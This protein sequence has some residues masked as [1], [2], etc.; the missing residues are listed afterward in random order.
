M[1]HS[2]KCVIFQPYSLVLGAVVTCCLVFVRLFLSF[3]LLSRNNRQL[4]AYRKHISD[5][6]LVYDGNK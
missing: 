2:N 3:L 5:F 1:M 4:S 6:R